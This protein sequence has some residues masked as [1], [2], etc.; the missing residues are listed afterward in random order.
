MCIIELIGTNL[1]I[2][3]FTIIYCLHYW[4]HSNQYSTTL[5]LKQNQLG[6]IYQYLRSSLVCEALQYS[7]YC[8]I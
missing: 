4:V 3:L 8:Y 6:L 7:Q 1:F 5:V 2:P